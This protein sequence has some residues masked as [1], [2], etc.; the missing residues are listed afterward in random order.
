MASLDVLDYQLALDAALAKQGMR[1][2]LRRAA[3][4]EARRVLDAMAFR[5]ALMDERPLPEDLDYLRA[6]EAMKPAGR[7]AP[8]LLRRQP[9]YARAR[10]RRLATTWGVLLVLALAVGGLAYLATSER[11]IPLAVIDHSAADPVTLPSA[12]TFT[13]TE[14]MTRL[15]VDGTFLL[16][17]ASR[18]VVEVRLLDPSNNTVFYE[19]Y[20]PGGNVYLRENIEQDVLVPGEWTLLVDFLDAQGAVRLTVDGIVPTR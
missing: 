17:K 16:S 18:G 4:K 3:V 6:L 19:P 1:P 20:Y 12:R 5:F 7:A 11:A 14:N 9:V 10:T 2:G 15:R 13:V 8:V